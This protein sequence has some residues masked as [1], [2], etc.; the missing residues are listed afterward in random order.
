MELGDFL[1]VKSRKQR[2]NEREQYHDRIFHLGQG[3]R[4]MVQQRMRDL[5]EEDKTDDALLYAYAC[6]KDFYLQGKELGEWKRLNWWYDETYM[7]P[8]DKIRILALIRM[9]EQVDSLEKYPVT[10]TIVSLGTVKETSRFLGE[11]HKIG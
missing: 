2:L 6:A 4:E 11:I 8:V 5:I 1:T 10:E 9:E 3:H 7:Y